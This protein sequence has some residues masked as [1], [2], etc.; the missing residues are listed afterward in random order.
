MENLYDYDQCVQLMQ[1]NNYDRRWFIEHVD[2][3]EIKEDYTDFCLR[4]GLDQSLEESAIM[5]F[6][7]REEAIIRGM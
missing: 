4:N 2:E 3:I 1:D 7:E 6:D 5:F